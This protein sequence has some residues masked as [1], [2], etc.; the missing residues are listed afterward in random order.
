MGLGVCSCWCRLAFVALGWNALG[1]LIP[2]SLAAPL[3]LY[4]FGRAIDSAD[5]VPIALAP[6]AGL[7]ALPVGLGMFL[8]EPAVLWTATGLTAAVL[9]TDY[10]VA[11]RGQRRAPFTNRL[12]SS[13]RP[14]PRS[15]FHKRSTSCAS[16]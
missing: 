5:R 10:L 9:V 12:R 2:L 4:L 14:T 11:H 15:R 8:A 3:V 16:Q 6:V 1:M 7:L 13:A